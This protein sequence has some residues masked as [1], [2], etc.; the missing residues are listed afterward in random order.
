M[1]KITSSDG[2][3]I[4]YDTLGSGPGLILIAGAFT[5]R[6]YYAPLA[7]ALSP[8]FTVITYDRRGRGDSTDTAPY[9]I[10]RELED[11]AVLREATGAVYAKADSSGAM[12]LVRAVAAGVPF[13]K[14]AIMEPPF[15]VE[16]APPAPDRYL[17]RL[18]DFIA[19]GNPGGAAE[20]FMVE[21][22]GQPQELVDT[23][24]G[25]PMWSSLEAMAPTLVYDALQMGDSSVPTT[26]LAGIPTETLAIHSTGSP[27]WMQSAVRA[28]AD[29][30][31]NAHVAALE[32]EFHQVS[33]EALV[34]AL[35]DFYLK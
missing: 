23:F 34:P 3:S 21:A 13:D 7:T 10:E 1:D 25:T 9:A 26:L 6:S 17:E 11:L 32:G 8:H 2:T 33:E 18:Q 35:T 31:P 29:A 20:L 30:L 12:L 15:R 14:L 24:K 27:A 19:T 4:A 5:D 22:V 28:T 16:G